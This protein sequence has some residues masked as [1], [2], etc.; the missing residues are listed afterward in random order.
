M[1]NHAKHKDEE[2]EPEQKPLK[3]RRLILEQATE[4]ALSQLNRSTS[5]LALSGLSAGLDIGFS[6]LMMAVL[7]TLLTGQVS[8]VWREILVANMYPLGFMLVILGRSELFTEHTTLAML[9]VLR[10]GTGA[11]QLLRL[12]GVV[13]GANIVGG[14]I[15]AFIL[16]RL[17]GSMGMLESGA[18]VE[19]SARMTDHGWTDILL[20]ATLA[21]WMMGLLAWL[22]AA[23]R[24]TISQIVIIWIITASIG[25][26]G[27]SHCI[28]G[29]VEVLSGMFSSEFSL[30]KYLNFLLP[31]TLGNSIGGAVFVAVIKYSHV[32]HSGDEEG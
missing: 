6:V 13:Y 7:M 16:S 24:D 9:P 8:E 4:D 20:N 22:V 17:A 25:L 14:A 19:L 21:G 29:N 10:G 2:P 11:K 12:W 30:G 5:G 23:A 3:G 26:A 15:F 18:L 1:A 32:S 28:V 31:T 27:L